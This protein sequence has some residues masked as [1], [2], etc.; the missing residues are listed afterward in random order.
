MFV[1]KRGGTIAILD[2]LGKYLCIMG[3][4]WAAFMYYYMNS[5]LIGTLSIYTKAVILAT[6]GGSIG[7]RS[8]NSGDP[9]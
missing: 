1:S 6:L 3:Y 7:Q 4:P 9:S 8:H 2:K 5:C